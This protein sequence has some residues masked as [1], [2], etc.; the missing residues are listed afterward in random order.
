MA[1][2]EVL[3]NDSG[4]GVEL[5]LARDL[6]GQAASVVTSTECAGTVLWLQCQE[7]NISSGVAPDEEPRPIPEGWPFD[8]LP[9]FVGIGEERSERC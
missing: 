9:V 5:A 2:Q 7:T 6:E 3:L 1:R 4:Q 8:A